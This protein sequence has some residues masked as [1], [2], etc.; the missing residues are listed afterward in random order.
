MGGNKKIKTLYVSDLDGT[1]LG[2]DSIISPESACMLNEAI[3]EGAMF[4]VATARTPATVSRILQP[5]KMKLPAIVMTGAAL[6]DKN[7]GIYSKL[8]FI[9][10]DTALDMLQVYKSS[11]LTSF[12]YTMGK[13]G[14]IHIYITGE[15]GSKELEFIA[16]RSDNNF[17]HIH[18]P[19]EIPE[20]LD[21]VLL[22]YAMRPPTEVEPVYRQLRNIQYCSPVYYF[23]IFG[24][25]T[26]ILEVFGSKVNKA[27]AIRGLASATGAGRI[28][29]FGDN[30]ND[31]PML[32]CADLPVAVG[33]AIPEVKEAAAVTIGSNI[34]DSVAKFIL[35]D[36]RRQNI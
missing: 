31:I 11:G 8:G 14:I 32:S 24:P 28:V 29:A 26:A 33:N 12:I 30:A 35:D 15:P 5:I 13:E 23:D 7:S 21:R 16:S 1:L 36:I 3:A 19:G 4:T 18:A 34:S 9:P 25:D 22:F 6:W 27:A 2:A 17:K 10:E 20:R